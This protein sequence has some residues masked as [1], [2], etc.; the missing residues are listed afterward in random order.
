MEASAQLGEAFSYTLRRPSKLVTSGLYLRMQHPGTTGLVLCWFGMARFLFRMDALP[1]CFLSEESIWLGSV[2]K[3]VPSALHF[4]ASLWIMGV[5][6]SEE[7]RVLRDGFG[8]QW[9]RW[10][11]VTKRF[12]PGLF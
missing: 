1:A 12:I 6:T 7:E 4:L 8:E 11:A 2:M 9:V 3:C 10:H 5:R